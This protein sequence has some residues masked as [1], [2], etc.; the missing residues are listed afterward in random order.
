MSLRK[1]RQ[2]VRSLADELDRIAKRYAG[3]PLLDAR[4]ADEILGYN[5]HGL[6]DNAPLADARGSVDFEGDVAVGGVAL[7]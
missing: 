4:P 1:R 6:H 7:D 5:E 2:R 3:L